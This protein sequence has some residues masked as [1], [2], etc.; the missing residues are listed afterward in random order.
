MVY[1]V[2][3]EFKDWYECYVEIRD[4]E[5]TLWWWYASTSNKPDLQKENFEVMFECGSREQ[6]DLV[7]S[8]GIDCDFVGLF[9]GDF[10]PAQFQETYKQ[11]YQDALDSYFN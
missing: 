10:T 2:F 5:E 1:N 11:Q 6:F 4:D 8:L 7:W 9:N 3:Y